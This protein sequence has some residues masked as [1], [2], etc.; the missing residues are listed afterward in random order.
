MIEKFC[1]SIIEN[2]GA[3]GLL[4]LGLYY[5]LSRPLCA[6]AHSLSVINHELGQIVKLLENAKWQ[7]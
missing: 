2:L 3:T 7:K 4:V 6:M 5:V 1:T